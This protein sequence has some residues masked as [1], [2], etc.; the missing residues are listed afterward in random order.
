M[1][2]HRVVQTSTAECSRGNASGDSREIPKPLI[3]WAEATDRHWLFEWRQ[4]S[5]TVHEDLL[6]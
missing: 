5:G 6:E 1:V 2:L 3:D 4:L